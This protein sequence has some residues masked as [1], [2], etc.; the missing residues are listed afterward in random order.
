MTSSQIRPGYT[1]ALAT[2]A[3]ARSMKRASWSWRTDTLTATRGHSLGH[4]ASKR[5]LARQASASTQSPIGTIRPVASARGDEGLR[6]ERALLG[7]IPAQER[8]EGE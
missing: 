8:L 3:F 6:D 7:V 2:N 5:A 1:P 4:A